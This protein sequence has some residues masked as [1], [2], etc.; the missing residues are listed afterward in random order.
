MWKEE[1]Y[2]HDR[3]IKLYRSKWKEEKM[4]REIREASLGKHVVSK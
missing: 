4:I 3:A 1:E 2:E